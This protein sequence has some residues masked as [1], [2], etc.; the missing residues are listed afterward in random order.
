M[1]QPETLS[2]HEIYHG[3][4]FNVRI[5]EVREDDLTYKREIVEHRGSAV[6]VPL[7]DDGTVGLVRQWRHPAGKYLLEIPAGSLEEGED[8]RTGAIRELEEEVGCTADSVD[9]L[10]SFYVSPGFLSEKMHVYVATG[11]RETTQNLDEDERIDIVRLPLADTI[12]MCRTNEIED[13]KTI[14]GLTFAASRPATK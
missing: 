12:E 5:D 2:S 10:S 7:F 4:T 11:L 3:K 6:I 1:T 8:P 9:L 14:I 13:A